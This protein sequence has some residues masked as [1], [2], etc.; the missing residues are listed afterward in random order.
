MTWLQ[1]GLKLNVYANGLMTFSA[2]HSNIA[3][4]LMPESETH[5]TSHFNI[6]SFVL[7]VCPLQYASSIKN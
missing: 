4:Q 5:L 7:L 6:F 3:I 1:V 2:T